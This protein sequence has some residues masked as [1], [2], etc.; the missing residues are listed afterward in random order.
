MGWS[1]LFAFSDGSD[2]FLLFIE[3]HLS[4]G[5]S[6]S[7]LFMPFFA[8]WLLLLLL[9]NFVFVRLYVTEWHED[10]SEGYRF[11]V[12]PDSRA[13]FAF[14]TR[15]RGSEEEEK[16]LNCQFH[17]ESKLRKIFCCCYCFFVTRPSVGELSFSF[18]CEFLIT[19]KKIRRFSRF[20]LSRRQFV[21][22]RPH[23]CA[24]VVETKWK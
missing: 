22:P 4:H 10:T 3:N 11:V 23:R 14:Q 17:W 8:R 24:V 20:P 12:A 21:N 19:P 1:I 2:R 16:V 6:I 15:T 13:L 5:L 9:F 7:P 18:F